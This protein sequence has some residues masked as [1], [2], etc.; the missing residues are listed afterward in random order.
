LPSG[1]DA[2]GLLLG[3]PSTMSS[4]LTTLSG[5]RAKAPLCQAVVALAVDPV[6]VPLAAFAGS[7]PLARTSPVAAARAAA[8]IAAS[9]L[10]LASGRLARVG[11]DDDG[12]DVDGGLND[13]AASTASAGVDSPQAGCLDMIR[14][15]GSG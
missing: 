1:M 3:W 8:P 12:T 10:G 14:W 9:R 2:V 4:R 15:F 6:A 7:G 13:T 11:G 5:S